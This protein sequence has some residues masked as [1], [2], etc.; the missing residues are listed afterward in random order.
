MHYNELKCT[1]HCSAVT[2]TVLISVG[3]VPRFDRKWGRPHLSG[4]KMGGGERGDGGDEVYLQGQQKLLN[5]LAYLGQARGCVTN[6]I[7]IFSNTFPPTAF[8]TA[9]SIRISKP[10]RNSNRYYSLKVG[11]ILLDWADF[12]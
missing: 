1:V 3:L 7:K 11:V 5:C 8:T 4:R 2:K 10:Q 12:A 6:N 9:P